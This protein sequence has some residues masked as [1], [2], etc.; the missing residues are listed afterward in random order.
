MQNITKLHI[1]INELSIYNFRADGTDDPKHDD[2]FIG[3]Q[4]PYHWINRVST[5]YHAIDAWLRR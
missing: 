4:S 3:H 5:M 2:V 1:V